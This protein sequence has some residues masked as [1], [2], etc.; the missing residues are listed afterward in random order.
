MGYLNRLFKTEFLFVCR[1]FIVLYSRNEGTTIFVYENIN[2][3]IWNVVTVV[4]E[5]ER[6]RERERERT[7]TIGTTL[8]QIYSEPYFLL[9]WRRLWYR[10]GS[11]PGVHSPTPG[12]TCQLAGCTPN[13]WQFDF[14]GSKTFTWYI[15]LLVQFRWF[16]SAVPCLP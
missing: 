15:F 7:A 13:D 9:L 16:L 5:G 3:F 6:E 2:S 4:C 12:L 10:T 14:F 11:Q 1:Y 8:G